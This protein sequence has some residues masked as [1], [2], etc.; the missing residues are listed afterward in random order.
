MISFP[1]LSVGLFLDQNDISY[2][3]DEKGKT[4]RTVVEIDKALEEYDTKIRLVD[5]NNNRMFYAVNDF[6]EVKFTEPMEPH[7]VKERTPEKNMLLHWNEKDI[8]FATDE[9]GKRYDTPEQIRVALSGQDKTLYFYTA[10]EPEY[11][12][13]LV[14]DAEKEE[15][16]EYRQE[17]NRNPDHCKAVKVKDGKFY[18]TNYEIAN[19]DLEKLTEDDFKPIPEE[20]TLSGKN[21]LDW[22]NE[23]IAYAVDAEGK[24]YEGPEAVSWALHG[25]KVP[26]DIYDS[27][28][29]TVKKHL[30]ANDV[31]LEVHL[32]DGRIAH[33]ERKN[34]RYVIYD[35]GEETGD[36]FKT[37]NL[38]DDDFKAHWLHAKDVKFAMDEEGHRYE[39][40]NVI[41]EELKK[42]EKTG[43]KLFI[44]ANTEDGEL[45]PF[46]ALV[47]YGR[48]RVSDHYISPEYRLPSSDAYQPFHSLDIDHHIDLQAIRDDQKLR[49]DKK[50]IG[51]QLKVV[52]K[53]I[54]E[55]EKYRDQGI[56][57]QPEMP[58]RPRLGF[59]SAIWWGIK[60]GITLGFGDTDANRKL[61][62][63]LKVYD[64]ETLPQYKKELRYYNKRKAFYD[65]LSEKDAIKKLNA[66]KGELEKK[67]KKIDQKIGVTAG[68]IYN[69][70][71][72]KRVR[73]YHD[74]IEVKLEGILDLEQNGRITPDNLFAYSWKKKA[75][76]E[77]KMKPLEPGLFSKITG[78]KTQIDEKQLLI[79]MH[80][81][82]ILE[83]IAARM[84]E[85]KIYKDRAEGEIISKTYDQN[86]VNEL[87]N[88]SAVHLLEQDPS[89]QNVLFKMAESLMPGGD[90]MSPEEVYDLYMNELKNAKFRMMDSAERV[91]NIRRE[92]ID[93]FG[94]K[95]ISEEVLTDVVQ[96]A[97][98]DQVINRTAGYKNADKMKD[99]DKTNQ[100]M[101]YNSAKQDTTW[102]LNKKVNKN[103]YEKYLPAIQALKGKGPMKLD[104]ML[105][106]VEAK[107]REMQ[108]KKN[109]PQKR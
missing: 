89:M 25:I 66:K 21:I 51:A 5:E 38:V 99:F 44:F 23:S 33:V 68:K 48:L 16:R 95:K 78:Q 56:P 85:D 59:F 55:A 62:A 10:D 17:L 74:N 94:E 11:N 72:P 90:P 57:K 107:S 35:N 109:M 82:G 76:L 6:G 28:E 40:V 27:M 103:E 8:F 98:A 54:A 37:V 50:E 93:R 31:S 32:T 106:A 84:V 2:A 87:N 102:V 13:I 39:G 18:I 77:Q 20:F 97:R 86:R 73:Q 47:K 80:K 14:K 19:K 34:D 58:K 45:R 105:T 22:K 67:V 61:K 46:A 15:E 79:N 60:K 108:M 100:D 96:L 75:E 9:E 101:L 4:Y 3:V 71:Y 53:E 65:R 43:K 64:E 91:G 63:D 81:K 42:G 52:N 83:Y 24:K 49:D 69:D 41:L 29:E 7:Y 92:M 88:G 1:K 12:N 36:Q 26:K 104:E 70:D 30:P